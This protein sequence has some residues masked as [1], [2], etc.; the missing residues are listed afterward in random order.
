MDRESPDHPRPAHDGTHGL[1]V[2]AVLELPLLV[3]LAVLVAFLVKTFVMQAFYIPSESMVPQLRVG[4]RVLV[5]KVA[6]DL[7]SPRRGD[8]VVFDSPN[9]APPDRSPYLKRAVRTI[10]ESVGLVQPSTEEFIKRVIALPGERVEGRDGHVFV[11]GR[12]LME[13]YLPPSL[14][15]GDFRPVSVPPGDL[16][17]MGDNRPNSSDSRVFGPIRRSKVV[18]RAILRIWPLPRSAFL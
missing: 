2:P 4:D 14:L 6:Y 8:I 18:G 13:P 5:S 3:A 15:V 12:Q 16:W 7:H 10:L 11:D 9:P 1:R 17:V